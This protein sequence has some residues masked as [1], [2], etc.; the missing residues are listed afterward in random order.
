MT[1]L[2][3]VAIALSACATTG[4]VVDT[5]TAARAHVHLDLATQ[6][7][8]TAVFPT[9]IAPALPSVDRIGREVRGT[10]GDTASAQIDLCISASGKVTNIALVESSSFDAFDEALLRDVERWQFSTQPGPE[11]LHT[12]ERAKITYRPY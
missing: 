7:D 11:A 3:I 4:R 2:A 5:D 8:T 1:K 12:C 6:A 9:A 10:L